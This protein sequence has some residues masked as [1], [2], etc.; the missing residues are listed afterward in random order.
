MACKWCVRTRAKVNLSGWKLIDIF[1]F[2]SILAQTHVQIYT[3]ID[4]K[5]LHIV[6]EMQIAQVCNTKCAL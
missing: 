6:H 5:Y 2:F 4:A 3:C 1:L